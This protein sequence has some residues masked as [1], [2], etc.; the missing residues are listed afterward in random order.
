MPGH[1]AKFEA[2]T[3]LELDCGINY[4]PILIIVCVLIVII[5]LIYKLFSKINELNKTITELTSKQEDFSKVPENKPNT[6]P[7]SSGVI[8]EDIEEDLQIPLQEQEEFTATDS[9]LNETLHSI[10]EDESE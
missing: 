8:K 2:D 5:Y 7:S 1:R 6:D 9:K 4:L 3:D 10:N